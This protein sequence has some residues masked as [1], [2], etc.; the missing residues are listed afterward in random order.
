MLAYFAVIQYPSRMPADGSFGTNKEY[1]DSFISGRYVG[2]DQASGGYEYPEKN[3]QRAKWYSNL[4]EAVNH[5]MGIPAQTKH[6]QPRY[7]RVEVG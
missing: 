7:L 5:R 2:I 6:M 1:F 4:E 3:I